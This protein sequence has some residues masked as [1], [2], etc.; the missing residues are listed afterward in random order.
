MLD[1]Q[2]EKDYRGIAINKVGVKNLQYPIMVLDRKN[3]VQHTVASINLYVNLQPYCRG[4]HMS[5]FIEVIHAWKSEISFQS[6]SG[7]L[8]EVKTSLGT[9]SSFIEI[10]FPFFI[11]KVAPVSKRSALLNYSCEIHGASLP[12]GRIDIVSVTSIPIC[13]V[14][15]CSK[16]ISENGAHNQRGEVRISTRFKETIWF[17]D[18]I[19]IV[20]KAASSDVYSILK[21][22]DEKFITESSFNNPKFVEDIARDVAL[23]LIDDANITWFSVSIENFESIH[24]HN[25]YA[26]ITQSKFM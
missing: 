15:P 9:D 6:V 22:P 14:C 24:N 20:E 19:S 21:R 4:V 18:I 12:E 3:G 26:N 25:A 8:N 10:A 17:E 1:I 11:E 5:R 2:K 13:S 7:L 23:L 16:A